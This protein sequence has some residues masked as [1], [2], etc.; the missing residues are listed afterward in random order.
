M[1]PYDEKFKKVHSK[2]HVKRVLVKKT[3]W[4]GEGEALVYLVSYIHTSKTIRATVTS[5]RC[6]RSTFLLARATFAIL[7]RFF[8]LADGGVIPAAHATSVIA[9]LEYRIPDVGSKRCCALLR[10]AVV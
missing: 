3:T 1:C 6:T 4:V 2:C 7:L 8:S 10:L 9:A 5:A